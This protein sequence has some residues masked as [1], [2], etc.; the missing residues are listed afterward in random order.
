MEVLVQAG[1]ALD[2]AGDPE[3]ALAAFQAALDGVAVKAD[4]TVSFIGLKQGLFTGAG[5]ER[6]PASPETTCFINQAQALLTLL[7]TLK[8]M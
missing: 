7:L 4:A 2:E 1:E 8:R 3:G 5:P 6:D